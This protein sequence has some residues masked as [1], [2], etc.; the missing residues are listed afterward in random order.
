MSEYF[1][2]YGMDMYLLFA[3]MT[4]DMLHEQFYKWSLKYGHVI[5]VRL[6]KFSC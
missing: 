4:T 3:E 1:D 2:K 6:G 5:S